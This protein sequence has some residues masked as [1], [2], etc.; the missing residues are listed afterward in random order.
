MVSPEAVPPTDCAVVV[1]SPEGASLSEH[2]SLQS[3]QLHTPDKKYYVVTAH[4]SCV[5]T[6][7]LFDTKQKHQAK[8]NQALTPFHDYCHLLTVILLPWVLARHCG[9][10]GNCRVMAQ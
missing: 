4:R 8:N 1:L 3:E 9:L 7:I 2:A 10:C 6:M 5:Q